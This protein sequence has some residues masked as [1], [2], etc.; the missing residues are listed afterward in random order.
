MER[1]CTQGVITAITGAVR[2]AKPALSAISRK[3]LA[4]RTDQTPGLALG[5]H[6]TAEGPESQPLLQGTGHWLRRRAA[7]QRWSEKVGVS[8]D[9]EDAVSESCRHSLAPPGRAPAG[10]GHGPQPSLGSVTP[11]SGAP[12]PPVTTWSFP[13]GCSP[14]PAVRNPPKRP[15]EVHAWREEVPSR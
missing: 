13:W 9:A 14:S 6:P 11:E 5:A 8:G 2:A 3:Q 15:Q 4:E 1:R 7:A 12:G 10:R